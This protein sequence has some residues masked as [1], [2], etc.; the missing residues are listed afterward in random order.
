M[1]I[2]FRLE[3][4]RKITRA[5][6]VEEIF[7]SVYFE[8]DYVIIGYC[9]DGNNWWWR[10]S[11]W[12]GN[13]YVCF[14]C[15]YFIRGKL[16]REVGELDEKEVFRLILFIFIWWGFWVSFDVS[17][18]LRWENFFLSEKVVFFVG[19]VKNDIWDVNFIRRIDRRDE[20]DERIRFWYLIVC[21][22]VC[23]YIGI[24]KWICSG[25]IWIV[26]I[27]EI[28]CKCGF[29]IEIRWWGVYGSCE[30]V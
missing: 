17:V 3:R 10:L 30:Y 12:F 9:G 8:C 27:G 7:V 11:V 20:F 18:V 29:I 13:M 25:F 1:K 5:G 21:V 24:C 26:K 15:M 28:C 19:F 22:N 16:L 14:L 2:V 23:C 6:F 4:R